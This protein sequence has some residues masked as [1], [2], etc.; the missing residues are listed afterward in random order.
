[1]SQL[2]SVWR[3]RLLAATSSV[4][5]LGAGAWWYLHTTEED[6]ARL[7]AARLRQMTVPRPQGGDP[8]ALDAWNGRPLLINFWATWCAPC[9]HEMPELDKF[10]RHWV[11][12]R[13]IGLSLDPAT[14]VL[15]FLDKTPVRYP[16]GILETNGLQLLRE[17]GDSMGGLPFTVLISPENQIIW[18]KAGATTASELIKILG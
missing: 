6:S 12:G 1:M 14:K 10:S 16:I 9:V 17:F 4:G 8:L 5:V 11:D 3:R 18:R 13:V 7:P 2:Q 15:A